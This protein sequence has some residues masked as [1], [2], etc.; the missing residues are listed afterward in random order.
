MIRRAGRDEE[1]LDYLYGCQFEG[2]RSKDEDR[3]MKAILMAQREKL[4]RDRKNKI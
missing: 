1:E 2:L 3:I 4:N